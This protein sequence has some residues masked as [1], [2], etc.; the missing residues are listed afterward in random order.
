MGIKKDKVCP[1]CGKKTGMFM[2][3]S[4][5]L[6]GNAVCQRCV[7]ILSLYEISPL[8]LKKYP[9]EEL[10]GIIG[11]QIPKEY[12]FDGETFIKTKQVSNYIFFDDVHKKIAIPKTKKGIIEHLNIYSYSDILDF[13]LLED[14]HSILKGGIGKALVGGTLFGEV[15][16]IVG[17]STGKKVS[18]ET[19]TKMQIKIVMNSMIQP[20][21]YM[22]LITK[23]TKKDSFLYHF[24]APQSQEILA[25]LNII[26]QSKTNKSESQNI[27]IS[28]KA[29][30]II[31]FKKL[32]DEGIISQEEFETKKKQLLS[33]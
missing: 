2:A 1:L 26:C 17:G 8:N 13:E 9:I 18:K 23:N 33:L 7:S 6:E 30:E 12:Q 3:S 14:G 25:L 27:N 4:S 29:D 32:M 16:A 15:G 28:S 10:K 19:C 21:V 22:D 31:K 11:I 20:V 24:V 5:K